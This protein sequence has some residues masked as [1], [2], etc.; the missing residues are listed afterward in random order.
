M[1]YL[2]FCIL[3]DFFLTKDDI[4]PL[5]WFFYSFFTHNL[6]SF[7]LLSYAPYVDRR[8]QYGI[9]KAECQ[10]MVPLIGR[11][12]V[13]TSPINNDNDQQLNSDK[14]CN[15]AVST[16]SL[17]PSTGQEG[18]VD[19]TDEKKVKNWKLMLHQ[20]GMCFHYVIY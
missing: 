19:N 16:S 9:W 4:C 14:D 2:L 5:T 15:G 17:D 10:K 7:G 1:E 13:I 3:L 12:R 6:I 20:I 8:E 18:L 11:G